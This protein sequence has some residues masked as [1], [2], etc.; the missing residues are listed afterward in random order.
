MSTSDSSM[1]SLESPDLFLPPTVG[2][3]ALLFMI[4]D[5][6]SL[7]EFQVKLGK[8]ELE[9]GELKYRRLLANTCYECGQDVCMCEEE[10][11]FQV[12]YE[13]MKDIPKRFF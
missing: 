11:Q 1:S 8:L 6:S 4:G 7:E 12:N 3:K 10:K 9:I 2:F 13:N 5:V